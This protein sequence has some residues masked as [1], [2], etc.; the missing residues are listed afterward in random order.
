MSKRNI[1]INS[2]II[3]IAIL[4][5]IKSEDY[6]NRY[7]GESHDY[8]CLKIQDEN[9]KSKIKSA[10]DC[11]KKSPI[12]KWKCCYFEIWKDGERSGQGCLKVRK[13]N[14]TDL[15]D[16]KNYVAEKGIDT[17]FTCE[18]NYLIYSFGFFILLLLF[19]F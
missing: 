1:I 2:F 10:D 3:I 16:A 9:E 14:Q 12:R 4:S 13:N 17:V 6:I 8:D 18:Q 19:S 5:F 7:D 11:F 15:N